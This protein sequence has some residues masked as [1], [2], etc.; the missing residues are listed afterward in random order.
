[1]IRSVVT[2][3]IMGLLVWL[4]IRLERTEAF[5]GRVETSFM[6]GFALLAAYTVGTLGE[7]FRLP[8]ITG[9]ILAGILF[10]P[11]V[12][13][14]LGTETLERLS[15]FNHMALAFIGLAAGSELRVSVLKARAKSMALLI[16]CTTV[17]VMAGVG[18]IT[19][20]ARSLIPAM[21]G[22]TLLQAA[23]MC[24]LLGV[25]AAAR[26]P[27]SAIA[28]ISETKARGPFTETILGVAMSMDMLILPLFSVAAALAGLAFVPGQSFDFT[29]V[30]ALTG[31]LVVSVLLGVVLGRLVAYYVRYGGPQ[32]SLVILGVCFLVYKCSTLLGHH[33]HETYGLEVHLEPLLICAAAGFTIQNLSRQGERLLRAME[34]V[35]LP[36]YVLFFTMAGASLN[37]GALASG[38]SIALGLV[39]ARLLMIFLGCRTA[40][41]LAGDPIEFKRYS[42]MGFITQAGL[43]IALA[44]QLAS[45]FGEWGRQLGTLL[46]AAIAVN[47]ILGPVAFKIALEKVGETRKVRQALKRAVPAGEPST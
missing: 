37:M 25:V 41:G 23:A 20:L 3:C 12:M 35:S 31:E 29:F 10:G 19:F 39:G 40:T 38:W 21:E 33:L 24:A 28:I 18:C 32:I 8:R 30:L 13:N 36:V 5:L 16:L 7:S 1:L 42:W 17:M 46:I 11:F 45:S 47:Q 22:K 4:M 6:L 44:T 26:S 2:L 27:S 9:Y 15:V 43:S 34:G 14:F